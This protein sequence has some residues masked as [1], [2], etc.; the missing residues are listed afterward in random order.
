MH[1]NA[2]HQPRTQPVN[3]L[4]H[5]TK[6]T[7]DFPTFGEI[8]G[9]T[10]PSCSAMGRPCPE[11]TALMITVFLLSGK[12][13]LYTTRAP[14]SS[15]EHRLTLPGPIQLRH[16]NIYLNGP[17]RTTFINT[18][19][20]EYY[21]R[22]SDLDIWRISRFAADFG[23]NYKRFSDGM[24]SANAA[25]RDAITQSPVSTRDVMTPDLESHFPN[26]FILHYYHHLVT[27]ICL[28]SRNRTCNPCV[29]SWWN[30]KSSR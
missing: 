16:P 22:Y 26:L 27:S 8:A 12:Y 13:E 2:N 20:A 11:N 7:V 10:L 19:W 29:H 1:L 25:C 14:F 9:V 23:V 30:I 21:V 24:S 5:P 4:L 18:S 3:R 28:S 6:F 15:Y 17:R